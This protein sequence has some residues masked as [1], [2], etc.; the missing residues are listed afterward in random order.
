MPYILDNVLI[1]NFLHNQSI[2]LHNR[3]F[4]N[5]VTHACVPDHAHTPLDEFN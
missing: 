5:S 3:I 4:G 1:M 2:H